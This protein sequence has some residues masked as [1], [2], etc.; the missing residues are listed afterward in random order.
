MGNT[1]VT[2]RSIHNKN[3]SDLTLHAYIV[4][5]EE[6]EEEQRQLLGSEYWKDL[7]LRGPGEP[8]PV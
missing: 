2:L 8:L 4:G 6:V 3:G 1:C 7:S 5:I